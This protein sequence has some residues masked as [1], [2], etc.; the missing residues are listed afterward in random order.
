MARKLSSIKGTTL[1][2][3]SDIPGISTSKNLVIGS[4]RITSAISAT[5]FPLQ[6]SAGAY[7]SGSV[8]IGTTNPTSKLDV[9]GNVRVSGVVTATS[10]S[11]SGANLTG[12]NVN[13]FLSVTS[14]VGIVSVTAFAGIL[15]VFGRLS[16]TNVLV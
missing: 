11:G 5:D 7:I 14:R 12:I 13:R 3:S 16:D 1:K 4:D 8:G 2:S 6:V 15:T 9:S 10:F